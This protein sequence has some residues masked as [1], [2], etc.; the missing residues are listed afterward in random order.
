M[1]R[2]LIV[3]DSGTVIESIRMI[4]EKFG[5]ES[6]FAPSGVEAVELVKKTKYDMVLLD[7]MMPK[8]GGNETLW[9]FER[10]ENLLNDTTPIIAMTTNEYEG[11]RE[12]YI[13]RGY[14]NFMP[15][16]LTY[17]NLKNLLEEYGIV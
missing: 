11:A 1:K 6:N 13:S 8:M 2:I 15:K 3:D 9:H 10:D 5:I 12:E 4:L 14:T 17:D 16:P 7:I